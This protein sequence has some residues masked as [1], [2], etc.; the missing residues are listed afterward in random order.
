MKALFSAKA[1]VTALLLAACAAGP[2]PLPETVPGRP[3]MLVMVSVAGMTP[4]HYRS[5]PG[6]M[7]AMP[8]LAEMARGGTAADR[9]SAVAPASTYPAH[10]TL[11]TGRRPAGHGIIA[12]LQLSDRGVR[13]APYSHASHLRAKTL[14]QAAGQSERLVASLGWP[15][16]VGAAIPLLVPDVTPRRHGETWM[17]LLRESASPQLLSPLERLGAGAPANDRT[18]PSRDALLRGL[19]CELLSAPAPP[20]LLLLHLGASG[21]PL[22]TDGPDSSAAREALA[23]VDTEIRSLVRCLEAAGRLDQSALIVVGDRGTGPVHT[24][25]AP[26]VALVRVGLM[27]TD[28]FGIATWSAI[29]R[30][31]GGSAFVYADGAEAA[32]IARRVL[33]EEA[34]RTRSFRV[35]TAEEMLGLGADPEAWFGLE[36]QPGYGFDN[37]IREPILVPAELRGIGG[38]L[39]SELGQAPG[40]VAWGRGI[41]AGVRVPR[42]EQIDVAPTVARLLGLDLGEVEGR[43]LVGALRLRGTPPVGAAPGATQGGPGGS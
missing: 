9:V 15:S 3:A 36:A 23:G 27:T 41:R 13:V 35:V 8:H 7:P 10:A 1:W 30:S 22:L 38:Y 25:I 33:V 28:D 18:G 42:M 6:R 16:T 37:R 11:L 14:W 40:F 19:A 4:D 24:A 17:E 5:G 12:D 31:N 21:V 32:L 34:E 29:S 43:A 26:N 20:N 39:P 2:R